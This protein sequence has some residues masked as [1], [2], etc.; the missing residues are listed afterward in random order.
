MKMRTFIHVKPTNKSFKS[1]HHARYL[2]ERE[3]DPEREAAK[4]PLLHSRPRWPQTYCR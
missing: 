2:S 1:A 4:P 3:R